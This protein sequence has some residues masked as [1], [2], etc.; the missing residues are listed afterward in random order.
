MLIERREKPAKKPKLAGEGKYTEKELAPIGQT[1][2]YRVWKW[3][4]GKKRIIGGTFSGIGGLLNI[5]MPGTPWGAV[6]LGLFVLGDAIL[7][8]GWV[9]AGYKNLNRKTSGDKVNWQE[10]IEWLVEWIKKLIKGGKS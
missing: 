10:V 7:G 6:G 9:H 5:V 1:F 2:G 8:T 3:W 4:N